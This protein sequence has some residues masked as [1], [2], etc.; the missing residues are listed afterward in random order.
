MAELT[1]FAVI[2]SSSKYAYQGR[3]GGKPVATGQMTS[4]FDS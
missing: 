4:W 3:E 1:L 2:R